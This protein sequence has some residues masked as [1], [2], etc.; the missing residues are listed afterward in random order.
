MKYD[1]IE[2]AIE[3]GGV[4]TTSRNVHGIYATMN[5]KGGDP[6][7]G[8]HHSTLPDALTSLNEALLDDAADECCPPPPV[9]K[10]CRGMTWVPSL[11]DADTDPCPE[12]SFP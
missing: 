9:C 1:W 4:L 10:T 7:Q 12:C 5:W 3:N 8:A 2:I 6:V 11:T